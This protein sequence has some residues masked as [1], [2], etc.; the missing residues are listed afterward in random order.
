[1]SRII[2]KL[3]GEALKDGNDLVASTNLEKV[4]NTT[5]MLKDK[6]QIAIVVGGGNYFRG[7]EHP[8]FDQVTGDTIGMLGT[9][10]NALYI[11]NILAK[12]NIS[13]YIDTPFAFPDLID[14]VDN[15]KE[16]Y[17][18]GDVIIF[19]GGVGKS[20]YSTDSGIILATE[21]VDANLIIKL[22]NVDGVYDKDPKI[23]KDAKRFN[24]LTYDEVLNKNLKIMDT[25]AIKECAN[26]KI[27]ILVMN[28]N[29]YDKIN[30]YFNGQS[31][32]TVIGG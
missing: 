1:M 16:L 22:T 28:F 9:V 7:R 12:N 26:R 11:K 25:Y 13:S 30:D 6:H 32:G 4:V 23:F 29:D 10:I 18:K 20:G 31:I 14:K 3:S 19:G 24:Y 2:I 5:K 8:E 21:K 15:L 17:D 27:K